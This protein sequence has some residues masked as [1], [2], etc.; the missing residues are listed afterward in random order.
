MDLICVDQRG[1]C[2]TSWCNFVLPF[3][4]VLSSSMY[5]P[6]PRCSPR[7]RTQ[8]CVQ[9][10]QRNKLPQECFQSYTTDNKRTNNVIA[11][12]AL[13]PTVFSHRFSSRSCHLV[14]DWAYFRRCDQVQENHTEAGLQPIHPLTRCGAHSECFISM[15]QDATLLPQQTTG[16]Y[17]GS[18]V[19]L[20][21]ILPST[22]P[23]PSFI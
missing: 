2:R 20:C 8:G 9:H 17:R 10:Q 16:T 11:T 14:N 23:W 4:T 3:C 19:Q 15:S 1:R 5:D 22:P 13:H 18:H 21:H 6:L 12:L 7:C